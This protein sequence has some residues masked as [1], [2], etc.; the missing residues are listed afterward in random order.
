MK[1][2][3]RGPLRRAVQKF[4]ASLNSVGGNE[5]ALAECQASGQDC[6]TQE[7]A[8]QKSTAARDEL[9][10]KLIRPKD[11]LGYIVPKPQPSPPDNGGGGGWD[12]GGGGSTLPDNTKGCSGSVWCSPWE[13]CINGGCVS[14]DAFNRCDAFHSCSF[15]ETCNDGVC[16]R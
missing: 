12:G 1:G 6:S 8:L 5:A 4:E 2:K 3:F 16:S 11:L 13:H 14:K 15:G 10:G 7:Q 9:W